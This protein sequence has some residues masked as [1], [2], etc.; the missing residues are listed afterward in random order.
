MN[1]RNLIKAGAF[2]ALAALASQAAGLF[3]AY[4]SI[5]QAV[6]NSMAQSFSLFPLLGIPMFTVL[7]ASRS[8]QAAPTPPP[9]APANPY[10]GAAVFCVVVALILAIWA[11]VCVVKVYRRQEPGYRI[12][13]VSLLIVYLTSWLLGA[14]F[15]LSG[16]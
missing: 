6:A 3:L 4:L 10:I 12:I 15:L 13:P 11:L 7:V 14:G 2:L 8:S 5:C 1:K 9:P 16:Q